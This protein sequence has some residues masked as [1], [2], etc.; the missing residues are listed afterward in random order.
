MK[1]FAR[2]L[3]LGLR[4][5]WT[6]GMIAVSS[7]I[8][9]LFWG[10]NLATVYPIVEV[11]FQGRSLREW[12][13]DN[14]KE[15]KSELVI[16]RSTQSEIEHRAKQQD[17]PSNMRRRLSYLTSQI[18]A[19]ETALL[20]FRKLQ[21]WIHHYLPG[22]P[23]PTL[24]LVVVALVAGTMVKAVFLVTNVLMVDRITQLVTFDLRKLLYRR[25]LRLSLD[26]FGEQRTSKLLSH[27]T[28]D[29]EWASIGLKTV[30]GRAIREPLKIVTCLTG[31]A[32]VSW[33]LLLFCL[34][35]TP[36][37][38]YLINL[39]AKSVKRA[40]RRAMDK[41]ADLYGILCESLSGIQAVKAF[42]MERAERRRFHHAAKEYMRKQLRIA[43]YNSFTKPSTELMSIGVVGLA[44]LAGGYL[45]LY[46]ETHLLGL[47]LCHRPMTFG[48][49]MAFF[50]LLAG[51]SDPFRKTAEIYNAI[52]SSAAASDRL[53]ALVDRQPTIATPAHPQPVT[54]PL[55]GIHFEK[56]HF[57]YVADCPVLNNVDLDIHAG[58]TLAI[59]G[60]NGCG[61]STLVNL[62]P[63][64]YDPT[65]GSVLWNGADLRDLRP[66]QLRRQCGVVTQHTLLFD[67]TV[68]NNL[69]YGAPHA[70]D[71]QVVVAAKQAH[72]H[73]FIENKL[74]DG[75]DTVIGATGKLLSGGQRQR[76]SLARAILRDPELL[77]LDEAT[78]QIDVESEQLIRQALADFV[79]HRTAIMI[80]HRMETLSLADRILVMDAGQ[81]VDVGTHD[82]LI[83]RCD[84]YRR[85]Q[86]IQF[87]ASA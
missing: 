82:Q 87:R 67:D 35:I 8:V 11:V 68:M 76:L 45:V 14:I 73:G 48:G 54:L 22:E 37:A 6:L 72:A 53:Y 46:Q 70:T 24:V 27:F 71:E 55:R 61:K 56:V 86:Q 41:M 4:Y 58:E 23:F 12:V 1:N 83:Q 18:A 43:F 81:V 34:I 65:S 32:L 25:T 63:R 26:S 29:M 79:Q 38:M 28:H 51:V 33:R 44:I 85:L 7:L 66:S 30:Y 9:A 19:E 21:P 64:F 59:V 80:T 50:A 75:Y 3:R 36:A 39:L 42:T 17:L 77:I 74:A 15:T 20:R 40:N 47:R 60:P 13:D 5:R 57:E 62:I 78:S 16:L 84:V 31:A 10:A 2:A 49:L 69:R 52:Q